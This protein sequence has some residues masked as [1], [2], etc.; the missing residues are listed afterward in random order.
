[1]KIPSAF[2]ISLLKPFFQDPQSSIRDLPPQPVL[3]EGQQEFEVQTI[4]DSRVSRGK[5]QYLVHWRG[6]GPEEREWIPREQVHASR[7]VRAF[8][9]RSPLK[10]ALGRPEVSPEGGGTVSIAARL[11][12]QHAS[13]GCTSDIHRPLSVRTQLRNASS[14]EARSRSI[15]TAPTLRRTPRTRARQRTLAASA[16]LHQ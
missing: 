1:M 13:R 11:R 10:P 16:V 12:P 2:H 14:A 5:L 15:T 8:H 4:L 6:F 7:L 3:V 9:H